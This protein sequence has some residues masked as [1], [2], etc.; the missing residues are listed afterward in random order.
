M[1]QGWLWRG[2][3]RDVGRGSDTGVN[4]CWNIIVAYFL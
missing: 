3:D 2:G 4:A 1:M